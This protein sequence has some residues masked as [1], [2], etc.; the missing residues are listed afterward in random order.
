MDSG[1]DLSIEYD[2]ALIS[3]SQK[4]RMETCFQ[5]NVSAEENGVTGEKNLTLT[6]H[7]Q[8]ANYPSAFS[9]KSPIFSYAI[10]RARLEL[11]LISAE[12]GIED[13][14]PVE[15]FQ[16][17][18]ERTVTSSNANELS[19]KGGGEF[20]YGDK[21]LG[22]KGSLEIGKKNANSL[23]EEIKVCQSSVEYRHL[24]N[25]LMH[26]F[27]SP[28]EGRKF[29]SGTL[30]KQSLGIVKSYGE[31]SMAHASIFVRE[32][33]VEA[34]APDNLRKMGLLGFVT[35]KLQRAAIVKAMNDNK[36]KVSL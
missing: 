16:V 18:T 8:R 32:R 15:K 3:S 4:V 13:V 31:N 12:M 27:F 17:M 7:F 26:W 36:Q 22:G 28:N 20:G 24:S 34:A 35:Y 11:S 23:E 33:D 25:Q 1:Q 2:S 19:L 9:G 5:C 30:T 6:I 21:K 10:K 14:I 29:L